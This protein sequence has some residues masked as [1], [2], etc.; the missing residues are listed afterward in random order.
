[1][2][3][4]LVN[5][6]LIVALGIALAF[7]RAAAGQ[8]APDQ[9]AQTLEQAGAKFNQATALLK[10]DTAGAR[11]LFDESIAAYQQALRDGHIANGGLYYNIAN[12]YMLKGDLGRAIL[13]Y[14]RAQTLT[15]GDANLAANLANARQRVTPRIAP[16]TEGRVLRTL[17]FWHYDLSAQVRFTIFALAFGALWL[18]AL[19]RLVSV[20]PGWAWWG[21]GV[22]AV[23]SGA[24]LTSLLVDRTEKRE[25][26]EAV[27][28]EQSLVGRKGPDAGAYEPSF[29][30]PLGPG[31]EV[32]II[33]SRPGWALVRLAD[34]RETWAPQS[35]LE[36]I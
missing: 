10:T 8:S 1:M 27:V 24:S 4:Q 36:V 31:V 3:G 28:I 9:L 17:L 11:A 21:A 13:N 30:E 35:A 33:E 7:A 26:R 16:A 6:L 15:P 2:S 29:N 22:L 14:R 12:A 34:G 32:R 20:A 18:V 5:R 23:V 25:S 19:L